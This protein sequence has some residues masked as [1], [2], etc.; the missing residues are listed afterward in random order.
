M[1][2]K[3]TLNNFPSKNIIGSSTTV[4]GEI[5]SVGDFRVDGEFNGVVDIKGEFI[6]GPSGIVSGE[7][8]AKTGEIS[9]KVS[10]TMIFE[11][12]VNLKSTAEINGDIITNKLIIEDGCVYNGSCTM[13]INKTE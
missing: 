2:N 12:S 9:G 11:Q 1:F 7:I 10:G 3:K 5:I 4:T 8:K 13:N 6:V